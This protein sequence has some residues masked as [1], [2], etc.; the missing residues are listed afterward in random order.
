MGELVVAVERTRNRIRCFWLLLECVPES[1]PIV[2]PISTAIL[3][4][5][6]FSPFVVLA[7]YRCDMHPHHLDL[8]ID[9]ACTTEQGYIYH[10]HAKEVSVSP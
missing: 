2:A 1:D 8:L 7:W 5:V 9:R 10:A 3:V 6:L 4:L